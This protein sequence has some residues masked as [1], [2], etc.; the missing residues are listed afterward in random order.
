MARI[1]LFQSA[2]L[3][4]LAAVGTMSVPAQAQDQDQDRQEA[5]A[6][7]REARQQLR[8]ERQA[9]QQQAPEQQERQ[10]APPQQQAQDVGGG[11]NWNRGGGGGNG[12]IGRSE[13]RQQQSAAPQQSSAPGRG[14]RSQRAEDGQRYGRNWDNSGADGGPAPADRG[15]TPPAPQRDSADQQRHDG[16]T[17][18]TGEWATQRNRTYSDP[19]R[20]S[21]YRSDR[22]RDRDDDNHHDR[23]GE[24]WRDRQGDRNGTYSNGTS[25]NGYRD[26]RSGD[27]HRDQNY[28]NR[29]GYNAGS[30]DHNRWD[31]NNWRRDTR[32]NWSGYRTQHRDL[33]RAGRYYS[34]YSNYGYSRLSIGFF[35]NSGFYGN[36]YWINDPYQYRLPQAYGPYRW[37]RYYDDV[38]LVDIY[39]GEVVDVIHNFFW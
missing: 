29:N 2:A 22:G 26:G 15:E 35:L 7:L 24:S 27:N 16:E 6:E 14:W 23:S 1:S 28:A 13:V 12:G 36:R 34:P 31:H 30:R 21:A 18:T 37:V 10:A 20:S 5:Q 11:R 3:A 4:V 8:A 38:L 17:R 39:S 25:H 32:Y 9:P 19:N 33:Y